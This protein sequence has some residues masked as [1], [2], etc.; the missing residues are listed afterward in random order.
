MAPVEML[1]S[2]LEVP[3]ADAIWSVPLLLAWMG[4]VRIGARQSADSAVYSV[5]SAALECDSSSFEAARFETAILT[6]RPHLER[7]APAREA[8]A[9][10][11]V[12]P[13]PGGALGGVVS[14]E[15]WVVT[16]ATHECT[17]EFPAASAAPSRRTAAG[18]TKAGAAHAGR[19]R[20]GRQSQRGAVHRG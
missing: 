2:P 7:G 18:S 16:G 13:S 9:L 20:G 12:A 14:E 6:T 8:H 1:T 3:A 4:G 17:L 5:S 19:A 11:A 10:V 15:V